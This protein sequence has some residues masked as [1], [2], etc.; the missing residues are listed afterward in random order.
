[1]IRALGFVPEE[2]DVFL[3]GACDEADEFLSPAL[4]LAF[5]FHLRRAWQKRLAAR[6]NHLTA[7]VSVDTYLVC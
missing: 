4:R 6:E 1:M 3:F 2:R 7:T 5:H